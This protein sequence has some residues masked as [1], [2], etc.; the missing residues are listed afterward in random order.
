MNRPPLTRSSSHVR[1][2]AALSLGIAVIGF[3]ITGCEKSEIEETQVPKG[4]EDQMPAGAQPDATVPGGAAPDVQAPELPFTIP[5]SWTFDPEP[6]RMRLATFIATDESG[7]IE[8]AITRFGG[9][10]G[11]TLANINR[12]RGQMGLPQVDEAGLESVITRFSAPGFEG[13]ES[14][15]DG[16]NG[17]MLAAGVYDES[18]DQTWFVRATAPD[19]DAADRIE[20]DLFGMARSIMTAGDGAG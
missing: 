1:T 3:S 12:W 16:D 2:F 6:R 17:V 20:S 19:S 13:Y 7:P 4:I 14:R 15:I 10:V 5:D 11:G 8:V 9:T 18:I